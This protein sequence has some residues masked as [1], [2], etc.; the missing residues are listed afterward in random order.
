MCASFK[1]CF[2]FLLQKPLSPLITETTLPPPLS[3][4]FVDEFDL[5]E[6]EVEWLDK[7]LYTYIDRVRYCH[8]EKNVP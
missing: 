2:I 8:H 3:T 5:K 7:V 4:E 1:K 6:K